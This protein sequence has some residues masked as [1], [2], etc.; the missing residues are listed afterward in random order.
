MPDSGAGSHSENT[1]EQRLITCLT[2]TGLPTLLPTTSTIGEA[3]TTTR[4]LWLETTV[5]PTARRA[6]QTSQTHFPEEPTDRTS[7][8]CPDPH[9]KVRFCG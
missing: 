9:S 5:V 2:N 6:G 7:R 4:E 3:S 8:A 1:S